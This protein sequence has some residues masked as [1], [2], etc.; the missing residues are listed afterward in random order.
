MNFFT[1]IALT[2]GLILATVQIAPVVGSHYRAKA[3]HEV[4][5]EFEAKQHTSNIKACAEG[6]TSYIMY[7][8]KMCKGQE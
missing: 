4:A 3:A 8:G 7:D 1:G 5:V 2:F 6:H